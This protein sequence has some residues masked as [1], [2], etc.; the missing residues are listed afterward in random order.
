MSTRDTPNEMTVNPVTTEG[1]VLMPVLDYLQATTKNALLNT[2]LCS[3][4]KQESWPFNNK[5]AQALLLCYLAEFL[6]FMSFYS[7]KC[8]QSKT[9]ETGAGR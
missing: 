8:L 3:Y 4:L 6:P 9:V 1:T 7:F 5:I 2:I